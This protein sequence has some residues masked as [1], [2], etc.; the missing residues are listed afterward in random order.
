MVRIVNG[1]VVD[2]SACV[3]RR[4]GTSQIIECM[5]LGLR[6]HRLRSKDCCLGLGREACGIKVLL[7]EIDCLGGIIVGLPHSP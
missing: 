2:E 6:C 3:Q 7:W 4:L 1:Q 5:A